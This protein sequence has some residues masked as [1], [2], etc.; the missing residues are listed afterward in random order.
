[1]NKLF[2]NE[3]KLSSDCQ[4]KNLFFT[5]LRRFLF[6]YF[7]EEE[8]W[9]KFTKHYPQPNLPQHRILPIKMYLVELI[10]FL[11]INIQDNQYMS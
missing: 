8:E 1:M 9:M 4:C 2:G 6:S 11:K 10:N 7:Y 3:D 5:N